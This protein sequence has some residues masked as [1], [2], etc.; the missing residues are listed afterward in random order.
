MELTIIST[1]K[2]SRV[3]N[4]SIESSGGEKNHVFRLEK[5]VFL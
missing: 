4:N 3:K 2:S 1:A 5:T